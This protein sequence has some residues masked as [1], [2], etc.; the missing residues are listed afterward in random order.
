MD[1]ATSGASGSATSSL[2]RNVRVLP[3]RSARAEESSAT[4]QLPLVLVKV[5]SELG[6]ALVMDVPTKS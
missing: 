4:V 3:R 6:T 1:V 2:K 5:I